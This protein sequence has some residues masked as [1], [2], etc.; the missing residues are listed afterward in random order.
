VDGAPDRWRR[1]AGVTYELREFGDESVLF[2]LRSGLTH[3]LSAA[4]VEALEQL[5]AQPLT[6]DELTRYLESRCESPGEDF[7]FDVE[8][9][10]RQLVELDLIEAVTGACR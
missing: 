8:R 3:F 9:L 6:T 1:H 5:D 2:D 10:V 7:A 4:A